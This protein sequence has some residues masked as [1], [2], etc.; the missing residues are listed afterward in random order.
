M[1]EK[2]FDNSFDDFC[3]KMYEEG[4]ITQMLIKMYNKDKRIN[5]LENDVKHWKN[6]YLTVLQDNNEQY[7]KIEEL[8]TLVDFYKDFQKDARELTKE[9]DQL[10]KE[11]DQLYLLIGRGDWSGLVD[12]IIKR[13]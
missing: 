6:G 4:L 3:E 8:K 10:K 9:N 12:S 13:S 5:E 7:D 2:R 11:L 1:T